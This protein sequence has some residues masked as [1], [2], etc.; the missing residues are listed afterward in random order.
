MSL[1]FFSDTGLN[2]KTYP[3]HS[4]CVNLDLVLHFKSILIVLWTL[5]FLLRSEFKRRVS[6]R[7]LKKGVLRFARAKV[8]YSCSLLRRL[9]FSSYL[10]HV[11]HTWNQTPAKRKRTTTSFKTIVQ[12]RA[13]SENLLLIIDLFLEI[14]MD[15]KNTPND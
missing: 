1:I 5:Q 2:P 6:F 13:L 3:Y 9:I 12:F 15:F 11:L 8:K 10:G 14:L 4:P 7:F